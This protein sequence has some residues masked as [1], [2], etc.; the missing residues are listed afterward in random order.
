MRG[1]Q[2]GLASLHRPGRLRRPHTGENESQRPV[3]TPPRP[4]P[5]LLSSVACLTSRPRPGHCPRRGGN[6]PGTRG[7]EVWDTLSFHFHPLLS[8]KPGI[9]AA[10]EGATRRGGG[11]GTGAGGRLARAA[12]PG[13]TPRPPQGVFCVLLLSWVFLPVY[14][15]GQVSPR[16]APPPLPPR[17]HPPDSPQDVPDRSGT[18]PA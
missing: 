5:P 9:P 13:L 2:P 7:R 10:P 11:R 1:A 4:P 17:G 14:I 12:A 6:P 8:F 15:A 3:Q 16:S 18:A